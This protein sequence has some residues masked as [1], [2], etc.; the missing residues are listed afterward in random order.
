MPSIWLQEHATDAFVP[1][2]AEQVGDF[3]AEELLHQPAGSM[4]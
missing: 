4:V 3:G 1:P 2:V